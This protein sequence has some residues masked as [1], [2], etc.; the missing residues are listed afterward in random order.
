MTAQ[1]TD[2][3]LAEVIGSGAEAVEGGTACRPSWRRAPRRGSD[4]A[5]VEGGRTVAVEGGS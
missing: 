3:V 5:T 2:N 4:V 1:W